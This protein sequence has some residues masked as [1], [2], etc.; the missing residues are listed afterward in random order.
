M[1]VDIES[2][3]KATA[4]S[5][6]AFLITTGQGCYIPAYQRQFAWGPENVDRLF[7]D[8]IHG[9]HLLHKRDNTIS[10]LG[11]IIAIHDTKHVTVQPIYKT[12][13][14]SKVMT[15]ID[16]QQRIST[17]LMINTAILNLTCR[18]RD[19]LPK[20]KDAAL[21]WLDEQLQG[22]EASLRSSLYVDMVTGD[23]DH[24]FYPRLVR[25]YE[26]AWSRRAAQAKYSSPVARLLWEYLLHHKTESTKVFRYNPK[27]GDGNPDRHYATVADI[28]K[29]IQSCVNNITIRKPDE[30]D[31]PEL[32]GIV[33]NASLSEAIWGFEVPEEVITFIRDGVEDT[34]YDLFSQSLRLI[35]LSKYMS[36][37]MAFTVVTAESE[38]DAFDMFEAL[39]TTGEPLT[40]FETFKPKVIEAEG[41]AKYEA[42]PSFTYVKGIEAYLETFKKAEDRQRATSEMLVPFALSETGEKLQKRLA[43]QRRWLRDQFDSEPL[44]KL[45]EQRK[46]VRRMSGLSKFMQQVWR[47][48]VDQALVFR[49]GNKLSDDVL[50]GLDVLRE[51]N[52]HIVAAPLT[53]FLDALETAEEEDTKARFDDFAAALKASIAFSILWR[54]GIGGTSTTI[55]TKYRQVLSEKID[56]KYGPMA[57]RPKKHV[58]SVSVLN[59]KKALS[60]FLQSENVGNKDKWVNA[61]VNQPIYNQKTVARYLLFLSSHDAVVDN[62]VPGLIKAGRKGVLPMLTAQHWHDKSY[63]TLEHIAPQSN[64]SGWSTDIYEDL[65]KISALGNLTLLPGAENSVI[66]NRS[67]KHKRLFYSIL[68][69]KTQ[70]D[71]DKGKA[72]CG[73]IGLT[74]SLK[75]QDVLDNAKYLP[76][77]ESLA[78]KTNDWTADFIDT[79]SKR[80]AELAWDRLNAWLQA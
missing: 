80:L 51:L 63:L 20:K 76:M 71:F 15:I 49:G 43:D 52:H 73:K 31:F 13:M 44:K 75:A 48:D 55:D 47:R 50:V 64:Q 79:R 45:D 30:N 21:V 11:T 72:E 24:R 62:G 40:A 19:K 32:L 5:S 67:W 60:Y 16:G 33:Q 27:D 68:S 77:C 65:G 18:L 28:F 38:D 10:F 23:P 61:V 2:V 17:F 12:E 36:D 57:V 70:E 29:H 14:P 41:I 4:Q 59:Y 35:V 39:N 66:G 3:F 37:R 6:W 42:S 9:L 7:E 53:R 46:F 1:S 74:I 56:G 25:S 54:S 26:D 69:A 22:Q 78:A 8:A 34:N 58:S